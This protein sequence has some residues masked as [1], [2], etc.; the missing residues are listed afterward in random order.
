MG[1][2]TSTATSSPARSILPPP[3][4]VPE[5]VMEMSPNVEFPPDLVPVLEEEGD[6]PAV[7]EFE[8]AGVA[9]LEVT[10]PAAGLAGDEVEPGSTPAVEEELVN[11]EE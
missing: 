9:P 2:K 6:I 7:A 3:R 5:P 1:M 8:P 4:R 11:P 10:T